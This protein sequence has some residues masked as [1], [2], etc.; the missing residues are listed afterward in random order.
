MIISLNTESENIYYK[1][2]EDVKIAFTK[3]NLK[4]G[5]VSIQMNKLLPVCYMVLKIVFLV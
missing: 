1:I 4:D 2:F 5:H 3:L